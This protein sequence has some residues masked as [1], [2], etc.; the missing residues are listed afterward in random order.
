MNI[1]DLK[2]KLIYA[3]G[4]ITLL[5]L[6]KTNEIIKLMALHSHVYLSTSGSSCHILNEASALGNI[7]NVNI[8][9]STDILQLDLENSVIVVDNPKQHE[10]NNLFIAKNNFSSSTII[11]CRK[12]VIL[13]LSKINIVLVN[14]ST[15]CT[16]QYNDLNSTAPLRLKYYVDSTAIQNYVDHHEASLTDHICVCV[17]NKILN[18]KDFY[19]PPQQHKI[20]IFDTDEYTLVL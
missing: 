6:L 12:S 8:V 4:G 11:F 5:D 9:N 15:L 19:D 7:K 17:D 2:E 3:Y 1:Y 13:Q 14:H 20:D 16:N 10:I 18:L